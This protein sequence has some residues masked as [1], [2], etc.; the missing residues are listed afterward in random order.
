MAQEGGSVGVAAPVQRASLRNRQRAD[1][2]HVGHP[3]ASRVYPEWARRRG[4]TSEVHIYPHPPMVWEPFYNREYSV[5][6]LDDVSAAYRLIME[7]VLE[8]F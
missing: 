4:F 5:T 1:E 3:A 8:E 2:A 7:V 6:D